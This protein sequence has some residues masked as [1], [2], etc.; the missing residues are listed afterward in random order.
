M[1]F[2]IYKLSLKMMAEFQLNLTTVRHLYPVFNKGLIFQVPRELLETQDSPD[3][4]AGLHPQVSQ[5]CATVRPSRNQS[6][7][8]VQVASGL[9]TACCILKE[10]RDLTIK[11]WVR[12]LISDNKYDAY[13]VI[14]TMIYLSHF[15]RRSIYVPINNAK[16]LA[17]FLCVCVC[18]II[19]F[20]ITKLTYEIL[21]I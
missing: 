8:T 5:S 6:A 4:Q 13:L 2:L 9:V 17:F 21:Q 20:K 19:F 18:N 3:P 7:L 12:L 16:I 14:F 10:M 15:F 11:T 1:T